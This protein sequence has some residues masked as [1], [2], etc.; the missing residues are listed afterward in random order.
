MSKGSKGVRVWSSLR[1]QINLCFK[2]FSPLLNCWAQ[3]DE[4]EYF[5][6][7]ESGSADCFIKTDAE[8]K[9][10]NSYPNPKKPLPTQTKQASAASDCP[11]ARLYPEWESA[12]EW[13]R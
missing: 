5:Y 1:R 10:V 9:L 11:V 12:A 8:P 3:G 13:A 4:G 6:V 7:L 2:G